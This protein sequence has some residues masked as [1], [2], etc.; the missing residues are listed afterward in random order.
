MSTIRS[1]TSGGGKVYSPADDGEPIGIIELDENLGDA[2][3]P[4]EIPAGLYTAEVQ[5][6]QTPVSGKGNTYF[7]VKFVISPDDLAADVR[8]DYPDGATLFYN[9]V[10]VPKK[11]DRRALFALRKFVES[12]GI[13]SNTTTIDPNEWMGRQARIRVAHGRY[14]G[15]TR[16]E[17]KSV[18][19][20]EEAPARTATRTATPRGR[21]PVEAE[22]EAKPRRRA[23]K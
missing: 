5:D 8:D 15:E 7:A 17:I 22:P 3:K 4:E 1:I 6:V 19:A 2:E 9:R 16:A 20:A 10:I 23:A 13:D 11:S 12:I 18:E 21:A 14:N